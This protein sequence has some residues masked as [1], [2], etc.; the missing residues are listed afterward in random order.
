MNDMLENYRFIGGLMIPVDLQGGDVYAEFQY[1][2]SFIDFGI[3]FDRKA[4]RWQTIETSDNLRSRD[5]KYTLNRLEVSAAL[6]ISDRIRFTIK[7]FGAAARS[8]DLGESDFPSSP[9]TAVPVTN[10]YAGVKSE[11]VY[12]N[13]VTTGLNLIEGSRG[14]ITFQHQQ[15]LNNKDLSFTQLSADLRH[16]QQI[17][18]EIV[19]AVRGYAGTFFGNSPKVYML[20]GMDNWIANK[21]RYSGTTS[22]G[23]PN[24]LGVATANQD[25]LFME[26]ATNLRGFNYG[27]KC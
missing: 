8:I 11:L 12:D 6:P 15:G 4:I 13:S 27:A 2:P 19:L 7:P 21:T 18:K 24:P 22:K 17:Y 9:P 26:Y 16:Y 20:G 25:I 14:K 3:R 10:Y 5:Y 23:Q 1:L